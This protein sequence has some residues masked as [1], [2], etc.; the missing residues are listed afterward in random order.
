[1]PKLTATFIAMF[2][3]PITAWLG[4]SIIARA[5]H[6]KIFSATVES[7]LASVSHDHHAIDDTPY[8][9]GAGELMKINIIAPLIERALAKRPQIERE[10][11]RVVLMDPAGARFCQ[12]DAQRLATY[13]ELIL[14]CGRYE[15]IDARIHHYVDE[16]LSIGDFVLSSG[17]IAAMAIC[18]ATIRMVAGVLHNPMSIAHESHMHGRLEGSHFTRPNIF[19]G[20]VVPAVLQSG[21]HKAIERWRTMEAVYRTQKQRPDLFETFPLSPEEH[22]LLAKGEHHRFDFP[23]IKHYD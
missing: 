4:S 22:E 14:I 11:K 9:G 8:G 6:L 12:Q 2:N 20:H 16:A 21:D 19:D 10:K 18:D 23:W 13:D 15:G 3:E 7:I 17:D 5:Q 1:M